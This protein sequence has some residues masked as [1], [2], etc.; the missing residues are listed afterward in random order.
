MYIFCF[1]QV[2]AVLERALPFQKRLDSIMLSCRLFKCFST[3]EL[4]SDIFFLAFARFDVL[5]IRV[6]L[7]RPYWSV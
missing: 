5:E 7:P 1:P 6:K 4:C 3:F 2:R